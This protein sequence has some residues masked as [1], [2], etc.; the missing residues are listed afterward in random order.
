MKEK[1]RSILANSTFYLEQKKKKKRKRK[2][3]CIHLHLKNTQQIEIET[4]RNLDVIC[5]VKCLHF[6]NN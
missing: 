1:I 4:L 6:V 3:I 2:M 5:S